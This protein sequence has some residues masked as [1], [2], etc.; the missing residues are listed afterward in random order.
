MSSSFRACVFTNLGRDHLD[1][2]GTIENYFAAKLRLFTRDHA[3]Q[4]A[5]ARRSRSSAATIR[6]AARARRG[7]R[8]QAQLRARSRARR[9]SDQRHA[10]GIDGIRA[11]ISAL[12]GRIE[13][14]S[15]LLGEINLLNILGA[16]AVSVALGI[17]KAAVV[18]GVRRCP[19]APGRLE[20]VAG[21]PGVTMLVDYAHKPDALEAVLERAARDQARP[22]AV[23][24]RMRRRSRSRQASAD[25]RDRGT[26]RRHRDPDLGQSAHRRSDD[27]NRRGRGRTGSGGPQPDRSRPNAA[28]ARLSRRARS[29]RRDRAGAHDRRARR[30]RRNRGQG[31][32]GLSVA[33]AIAV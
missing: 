25:G 22:A 15:P 32:R 24:L 9:A 19:G 13:I 18:E 2:H 30:R 27:D 16:A 17:E 1:Y 3:R 29:P 10:T 31:S 26:A 11:T 8:R 14:D 28:G 20:R 12:G 33:S 4:P 23:R 6:S 5:R 21:P 7:A